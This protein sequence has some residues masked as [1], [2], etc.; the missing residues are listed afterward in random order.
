MHDDIAWRLSAARGNLDLFNLLTFL[1]YHNPAYS[2][3]DPEQNEFAKNEIN[4]CLLDAIHGGNVD[5][6]KHI[7]SK[8]A[9]VNQVD[10]NK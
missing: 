10:A 1:L 7:L 6:V 8:G 2:Y 3:N 9:Q 4:A 5:I